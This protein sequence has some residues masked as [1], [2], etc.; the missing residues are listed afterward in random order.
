[1][2]RK[3]ST[4][5]RKVCSRPA[6]PESSSM[7]HERPLSSR[8]CRFAGPTTGALRGDS[9]MRRC[10]G[11]SDQ[12]DLN[13]GS[14]LLSGALWLDHVVFPRAQEYRPRKF[15]MASAVISRS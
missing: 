10:F 15:P 8:S 3:L 5:V 9:A 2:S 12:P 14:E 6:T 1:M 13:H 4:M 7:F 11:L